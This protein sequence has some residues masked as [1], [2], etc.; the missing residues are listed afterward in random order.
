VSRPWRAP[1]SAPIS[2][3]AGGWRRWAGWLALALPLIALALW[4]SRRGFVNPQLRLLELRAG[5]ARQG[6][7]ALS[8]LRYAYPPLP[9][10]LA[11]VLPGG[12]L[13]LTVVTCL[14]S[15]TTLQLLAGRLLRRV[16]PAAAIA[17]L[18]TFVA[19]PAMWYAA[20]QLLAP[21]AALTLLAVALD[22]FIAFAADGRTEG[23]FK[24]GIALAL[25]FCFDPGALLYAAVMCAFA[26]LVSH[27]RYRDDPAA[28]TGIAAVLSFPVAAVTAGWL[29]LVWKFSGAIPGSL[30]YQPGAHLFAFPGGPAA[31]LARAVG[32][33]AAALAH[34]PLYPLAGLLLLYRS[35]RAAA[36]GLLLPVAALTGALWFGFAYSQV[37]AYFLFTMLALATIA[38]LRPR[39]LAPLLACAAVCQAGLAIVWA[40][41]SPGFAAW[42]HAVL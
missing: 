22:G 19:V 23:G 29:F 8:G 14:C 39:R 16:P 26:P 9:T 4:A 41:A 15:A 40:P 28:M 11:L 31:A 6:G 27:A 37:A 20:S 17:L 1:A 7:P 2:W 33:A 10:L 30:H 21:V 24:A 25:S 32:A 12:A 42:L 35:R 38:S 5:L 18:L 13:A 34:A 3:P 36:L